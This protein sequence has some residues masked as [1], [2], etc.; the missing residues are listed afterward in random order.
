MTRILIVGL[1]FAALPAA[2]SAEPRTSTVTITAADMATP[3]ARD[4][5]NRRIGAAIEEVCGSYAAIESAQVPEMDACWS[6]AKAQVAE[7]LASIKSR[8]SIQLASH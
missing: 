4:R 6:A 5:L 8:T 2:A 7:R 1:L 3:A